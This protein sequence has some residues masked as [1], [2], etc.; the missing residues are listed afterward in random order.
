[1]IGSGHGLGNAEGVTEGTRKGSSEL[2][3]AIRNEFGKKTEAFPDM[4]MI[5]VGRTF[6]GDVGMTWGEDGHFG[7]IM[8][9]KNGN[10]VESVR[11]GKSYNEIHGGGRERSCILGRNNGE[12]GDGSA[13]GLVFCQLANRATV[14][15]I[16]D[17]PTHSRPEELTANKII[18]FISTGVTSSGG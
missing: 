11:R 16:K 14:D 2:G 3:S 9:H 15:I 17:K 6:C 10:S 13:I 1:M 18:G 5:Q 4:V 8:I 7:D 12:K